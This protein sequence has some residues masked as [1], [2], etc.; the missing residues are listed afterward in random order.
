MLA[1]DKGGGRETH[2]DTITI[3]RGS[4][5]GCRVEEVRRIWI[6]IYSE[7]NASRISSWGGLGGDIREREESNC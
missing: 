7:G 5:Q 4:C 2:S 6:Q 3:A 1:G